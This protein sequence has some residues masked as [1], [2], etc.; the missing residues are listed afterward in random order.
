M[1]L[2]GLSPATRAR[3]IAGVEEELGGRTIAE[4][5]AWREARLLDWLAAHPPAAAPG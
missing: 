3:L 4:V 5:T 2:P 1:R